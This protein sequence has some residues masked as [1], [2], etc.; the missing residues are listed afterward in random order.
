MATIPKPPLNKV[1]SVTVDYY[2][3]LNRARGGREEPYPSYEFGNGKKTFWSNM[4]GEGV[5][6]KPVSISG[7]VT[8]H[9]PDPDLI[10]QNP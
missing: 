5:Y 6:D 7:N 3:L 4:Q 1:T 8:T 9:L 10:S 2:T